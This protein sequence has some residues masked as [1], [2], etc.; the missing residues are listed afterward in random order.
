MIFINSKHDEYQYI[1]RNINIKINNINNINQLKKESIKKNISNNNNY[2]YKIN[3]LK[4]EI[5]SIKKKID[6]INYIYKECIF[7]LK[8]TNNVYN[9]INSYIIQLKN[10]IQYKNHLKDTIE[11]NILFQTYQKNILLNVKSSLLKKYYIEKK[12]EDLLNIKNIIIKKKKYEEIIQKNIKILNYLDIK[13][14]NINKKIIILNEK[15]N[16]LIKEKFEKILLLKKINKLNNIYQDISKI[17]KLYKKIRIEMRIKNIKSLSILLNEIFH[18]INQENSYSN[19][20]LDFEYNIKII[21]NMGIELEP[22][23]LSFGERSIF[24]ISLKCAIYKLLSLSIYKSSTMVPLILDEPTSFL[25]DNNIQQLVKLI[26]YMKNNCIKQIIIV[27]HEKLLIDSSDNTINI[28]KN[29]Y[30]NKSF[31]N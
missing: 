12:K 19:I 15:K 28:K 29:I 18:Y 10:N 16:T 21:D 30:T 3:I 13:K 7:F 20:K 9:F 22:K 26:E 31:I 23:Q 11:K 8:K 14:N 1:K 5:I 24:N 4:K 17:E 6:I 2:L 25:D 27:S